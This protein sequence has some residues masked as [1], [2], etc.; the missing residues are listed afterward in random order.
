MSTKDLSKW[1]QM[2][3]SRVGDS[4]PAY[5]RQQ[6]RPFLDI[7]RSEIYDL[8]L[9][10]PIVTVREEGCGIA[11]ITKVLAQDTDPKVVKYSVMDINEDQVESARANLRNLVQHVDIQRGNILEPQE[12]VSIIHGHGVLEHFS[13]V[14]IH[15]ILTRQCREA[16]IVTHYVPLIGW[17]HQSF[18]DERLLTPVHWIKTHQPCYWEIFNDGKDLAMVWRN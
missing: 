17:G 13:D 6:Y 18:G 1:G 16:G 14:Q 4:Y 15:N 5:C 3:L 10:Q 9:S 2:Y 7:I 11:T 8:S 12:P